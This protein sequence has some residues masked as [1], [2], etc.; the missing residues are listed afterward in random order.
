[1]RR[2]LFLLT[3]VLVLPAAAQDVGSRQ[4]VVLGDGRV[5]VGTVVRAD[6]DVV[7]LD[8]GGLRT[9]IPRAQIVEMDMSTGRFE[10]TDPT[11]TR[12]FLTPTARTLPQGAGRFSSYLILLPSLAYGI[13]GN[14]DVSV[15]ATIPVAGAGTMSGNLK[16]GLVQTPNAALAVGL[17]AGTTYGPGI[18]SGVGGTFY[19]VGTMGSRESSVSLGLYGVYTTSSGTDDFEVGNGAGIVLGLEK[20][21]SNSIKVMSENLFITAFGD[22]GGTG[23]VSTLGLRF[24]GDRLSAD[25]ALPLLAFASEGGSGNSTYS[26]FLP[27]PVPFFGLAYNFGR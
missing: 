24:F 25:V 13:T 22:Q 4:R 15:A 20:Q 11:D 27:S 8:V 2:L 14:L 3:L 7:V 16:Y 17:S 9:E 5:I 26:D 1:M 10:S 23:G 12:L 19:G 6:A 18:D 21:V